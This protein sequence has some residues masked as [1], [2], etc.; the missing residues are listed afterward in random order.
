VTVRRWYAAPMTSTFTTEPLTKERT[1]RIK[2]PTAPQAPITR[3]ASR[4][5][6]IRLR[7]VAA[8]ALRR[9]NL[10]A[11]LLACRPSGSA[12][13]ANGSGC[14]MAG[15]R[16]VEG[17]RGSH[18]SLVTRRETITCCE[19][20]IG[21]QQGSEAADSIRTE[22]RVR[23]QVSASA[24]HRGPDPIQWTVTVEPGWNEIHPVSEIVVR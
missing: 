20:A 10:G 18:R 23:V 4:S 3:G 15:K 5:I 24:E 12:G 14:R 13:G 2:G 1:M 17:M 22:L 11:I 16:V 7:D 21:N 19:S 8:Q 6:A 9:G